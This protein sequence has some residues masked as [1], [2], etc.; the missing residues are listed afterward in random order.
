VAQS[1]QIAQDKL[2]Q[3]GKDP[4]TVQAELFGSD[5]KHSKPMTELSKHSKHM[6]FENLTLQTNPYKRRALA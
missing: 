3:E 4:S 2:A 1:I 6:L 5:S